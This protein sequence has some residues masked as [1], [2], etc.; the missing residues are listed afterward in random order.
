VEEWLDKISRKGTPWWV[1]VLVA[2][3]FLV[4][5]AR[6]FSARRL[7]TKK[8]ILEVAKSRA[9]AEALADKSLASAAAFLKVQADTRDKIRNINV[10]LSRLSEASKRGRKRILAARSLTELQ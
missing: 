1:W 6:K 10:E 3:S 4:V 9:A 8:R 5:S 7:R 2:V